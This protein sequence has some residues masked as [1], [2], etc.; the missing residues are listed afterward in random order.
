M[1]AAPAGADHLDMDRVALR[2]TPT[3]LRRRR[4]ERRRVSLLVA[5][6][7]RLAARA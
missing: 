3:E 6:L 7:T 5:V 1:R 4:R 2:P